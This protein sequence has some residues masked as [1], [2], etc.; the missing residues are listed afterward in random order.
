[1]TLVGDVVYDDNWMPQT[2]RQV[3]RR[4]RQVF[5]GA[6]VCNNITA[7]AA[8][9]PLIHHVQLDT[10]TRLIRS[11]SDSVASRGERCSSPWRAIR[12][13]GWCRLTNRRGTSHLSSWGTSF[14]S[15][16]A[17]SCSRRWSC[18]TRTSC[19]RSWGPSSSSSSRRTSVSLKSDWSAS[20]RRRWRPAVTACPSSTTPLSTGIGTSRRRC[21][22][23]APCCP[24]QVSAAFTDAAQ[25]GAR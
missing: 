2:P 9:N 11:W 24:P 20:S 15:S 19:A 8:H 14:I 25:T 7:A 3:Q 23:P 22:S 21:F 5:L 12:A 6:F 16:S 17:R 1:M 10:L 18:H 13:C 4:G